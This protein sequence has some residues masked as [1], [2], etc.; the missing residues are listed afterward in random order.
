MQT[1]AL[2]VVLV[3]LAAT[4]AAVDSGVVSYGLCQTACNASAVTCYAG[5]GYIFGTV[6]A[7]FGAPAAVTTCNAALSACMALCTPL[8]LSPW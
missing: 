7:G 6:T 2:A 5:A 3:L 8:L 1:N 4:F